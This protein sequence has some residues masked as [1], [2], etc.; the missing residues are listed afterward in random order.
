MDFNKVILIG[1][2][3]KEIELQSTE[4]GKQYIQ[5][6][7]AVGNGKDKEGNE[8]KTDF[9]TCIAWEKRAEN[10]STYLHKGHRVAIEG[11]LKVE[12]YDGQDGN[13]KYR[14]YVLVETFEF[15][16]NKS[17]DNFVPS[18]PDNSGQKMT[19]SYEQLG[20]SFTAE[21]VDTLTAAD[22]PF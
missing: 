12:S 6:N 17:K 19:D 16:E 2:L 18:E 5:F 22:L 4:S 11:R 21:Q 10:L 1:R 8:R 7:I 3:T 9:I 15:L 20:N 13:K 14:N